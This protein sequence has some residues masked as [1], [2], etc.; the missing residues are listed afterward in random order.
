MKTEIEYYKEANEEI[1][2]YSNEKLIM[3]ALHDLIHDVNFI[4]S[5]HSFAKKSYRGNAIKIQ[6]LKRSK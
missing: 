4:K 1:A 6:L 3:A 5:K 2:K